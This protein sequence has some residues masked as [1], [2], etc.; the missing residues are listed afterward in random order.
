MHITDDGS[1]ELRKAVAATTVE[2]RPGIA[3]RL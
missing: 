3:T 1:I 2:G